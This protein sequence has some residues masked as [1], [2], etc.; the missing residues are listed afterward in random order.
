MHIGLGGLCSAGINNNIKSMGI[1]AAKGKGFEFDSG[2]VCFAS[3]FRSSSVRMQQEEVDGKDFFGQV[4][5]PIE[6]WR[7][8]TFPFLF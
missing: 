2:I 5:R 1:S 3:G 4:V 7:I 6:K 8:S